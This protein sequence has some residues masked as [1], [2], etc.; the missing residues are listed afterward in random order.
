MKTVTVNNVGATHSGIVTNVHDLAVFA[1]TVKRQ[2][3]MR[4]FAPAYLLMTIGC[5]PNVDCATDVVGVARDIGSDRYAVTEVR[6][7]GATTDFTTVVRVGRASEPQSDAV[8]V[9]VADS[10][11][12]QATTSERGAIA[13]TV[14]WIAPSS[15]TIAHDPQARV[16][17]RVTAAKGA[18]I[19]VQSAGPEQPASVE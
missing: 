5:S 11:P 14:T 3:P 7:C 6:N 16:F 8:E 17:K 18:T 4:R 19:S 12:G 9:F 10:G 13:T 15:L 1:F 2:G